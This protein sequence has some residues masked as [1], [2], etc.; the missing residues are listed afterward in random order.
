MYGAAMLRLGEL[1]YIHRLARGR[2]HA[3]DVVRQ[4]IEM[5][6][7]LAL[8]GNGPRYYQLAG[9]WRKDVRWR[10][11]RRHMSYR[12]YQAEL[13]RLNPMPYRKLSQSKVAEKAILTMMGIPTP[14]CVGFLDVECG[15]DTRGAPLRNADDLVRLLAREPAD[16]LCFKLIEGH[17]GEGFVAAEVR[18]GA[19]SARFRPL[20]KDGE[21]SA[22]EFV[23][24]LGLRPGHPRLIETYLI[25]HPAYAA[26]NPTSVNTLRLWVLR[27]G[28]RATTRLGYLRIGR[29]GSLVDNQSAGGIVAPIDLK[30]GRLSEATDGRPPRNVYRQHPDHGAPIE[31]VVLPLLREATALAEQ[32]MTVFPDLNFAGVDVAMTPDGPMIIETNL[33]PDRE[34]AAYVGMPTRDVFAYD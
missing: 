31:G 4:W 6:A 3:K 11:M 30:T 19:N 29:G 12:E 21:M 22:E 17:G 23:A 5:A 24:F 26:F 8:T 32:C 13:D 15:R 33:Q 27:R 2:Q 10:Q 1:G 9:F 28:A 7:L 20:N 16:R 14:R 25:Q 18:R 34:G